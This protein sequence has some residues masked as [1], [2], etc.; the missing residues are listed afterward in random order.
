MAAGGAGAAGCRTRPSAG[1][2][3]S[4]WRRPLRGDSAALEVEVADHRPLWGRSGAWT[5]LAE[6]RTCV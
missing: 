4:I 3:G 5:C 2:V 6:P 1:L